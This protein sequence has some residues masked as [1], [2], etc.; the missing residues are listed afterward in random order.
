MTNTRVCPPREVLI[1]AAGPDAAQA[2]RDAVADHLIECAACAD[3]F[4]LLQALAPWASEHAPAFAKATAR[5]ARVPVWA[6]AAAAVLAL[7]AVGLTAEVR[8]LTLANRALELS[9]SAKATADR[10]P[11]DLPLA[12]A[13]GQDARLADQQKTIRTLEERLRAA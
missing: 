4:R 5:Q 2:G 13:A 6:Y 10:H 11:G 8:R 7:I 9:A 12:T 3:E 1:D